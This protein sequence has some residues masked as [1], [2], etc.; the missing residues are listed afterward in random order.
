MITDNKTTHHIE[1]KVVF[2]GEVPFFTE[3]GPPYHEIKL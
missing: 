2:D 1:I 3:D